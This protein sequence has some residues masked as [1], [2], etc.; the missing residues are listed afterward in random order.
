MHGLTIPTREDEFYR[1]ISRAL[2]D[3]A[4]ALLVPT[5]DLEATKH[6]G[7]ETMGSINP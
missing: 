2:L 5:R 7:V 4:L 6:G 1:N 3:K